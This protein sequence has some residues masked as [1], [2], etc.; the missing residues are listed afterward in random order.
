LFQE[1]EN[2]KMKLSSTSLKN[3]R[4]NNEAEKELYKRFNFDLHGEDCAVSFTSVTCDDDASTPL[5]YL[6]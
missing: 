2:L 3:S 4:K 6:Y 1:V 5:S